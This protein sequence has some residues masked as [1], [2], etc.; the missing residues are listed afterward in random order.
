MEALLGRHHRLTLFSEG[1]FGFGKTR[2]VNIDHF[3]G[4]AT[5]FHQSID[6][7]ILYAYK[8]S[9]IWGEISLAYSYRVFAKDFPANAN[10]WIVQ[11]NFPFSMF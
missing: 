6:V 4:Y 8:I 2:R 5:I 11:Y 9:S 7:G 1:Y 10:T 3:R